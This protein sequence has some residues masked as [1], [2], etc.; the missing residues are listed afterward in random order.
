MVFP[1]SAIVVFPA[2]DLHQKRKSGNGMWCIQQSSGAT[3]GGLGG[4]G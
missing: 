1:F 2:K 4:S 3:N